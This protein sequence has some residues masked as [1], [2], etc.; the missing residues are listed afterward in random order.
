[1]GVQ[2][3]DN[4]YW[5]HCTDLDGMLLPFE[6]FGDFVLAM[7][8]R[9]L[10]REEAVK[11]VRLDMGRRRLE[12]VRFEMRLGQVAGQELSLCEPRVSRL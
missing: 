10:T 8:N 1:M 3:T 12:R 6:K 9:W 5:V 7:K 4:P 2:D 11:V